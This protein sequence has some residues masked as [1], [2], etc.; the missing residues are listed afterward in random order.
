MARTPGSP[1]PEPSNSAPK[2]SLWE[3]ITK[4]VITEKRSASLIAKLERAR[5]TFAQV[6]CLMLPRDTQII[7]GGT[8]PPGLKLKPYWRVLFPQVHGQ[9]WESKANALA[10]CTRDP[11]SN[12]VFADKILH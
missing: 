4:G 2:I 8:V 1:G 10:A 6:K 9:I 3:R 5:A 7:M 11:H 12:L